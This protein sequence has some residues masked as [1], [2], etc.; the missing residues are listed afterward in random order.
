MKFCY[1]VR[2]AIVRSEFKKI[3]LSKFSYAY[4][5]FSNLELSILIGITYVGTYITAYNNFEHRSARQTFDNSDHEWK[6]SY[7]EFRIIKTI[8]AKRKT[9]TRVI[10]SVA[11]ERTSN[12]ALPYWLYADYRMWAQMVSIRTKEENSK[13]RRTRTHNNRCTV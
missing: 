2:K 10:T 6:N 8:I 1:N 3:P 4:L 5:N 11:K 13:K 12:R 9:V 7:A